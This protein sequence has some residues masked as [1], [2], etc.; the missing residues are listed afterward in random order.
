MLI[1]N[2]IAGEEA[3]ISAL[4]TE[5]FATAPH[6]SGTEALIVER[7]RAA[8]ALA[9]SLVAEEA[10]GPAGHLAA[11]PALL[12]G[13]G[14]WMAI[15]PLAVRPE[16]QGRGLGS[17][18]MRAALENLRATGAQGAVLVGDPD[19]YA[20][21]GFTPRPGLTTP[22]VSDIY[23]LGLGF[24]EGAPRGAIAFHPAFGL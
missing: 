4:V 11:S 21:F 10:G 5:A 19:Y 13:Q 9:L 24:G 12:D 18:L 6:A 3:L 17:A 16:R 22:G 23:V 14:G 1:R 2:E 15:G 8:G 20:R 7:L